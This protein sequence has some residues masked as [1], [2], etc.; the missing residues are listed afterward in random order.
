[1]RNTLIS[2]LLLPLFAGLSFSVTAALD[3]QAEPVP[4]VAPA[5]G[6]PVQTNINTADAVTLQRELNGIGQAKAQA[7]IAYRD[8]HGPFQSVDE[9]LEIKG[10][11]S[12][13]LERNREKLRLE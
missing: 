7:I 13:L 3:D 1:M 10:I 9:I 4:I 2:Y 8:A 12:A 11:G 6:Q 5:A